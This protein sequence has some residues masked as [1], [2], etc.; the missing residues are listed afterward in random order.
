MAAS[1]MEIV[2]HLYFLYN[3]KSLANKILIF[4]KNRTN[5]VHRLSLKDMS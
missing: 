4:K 1:Y 2:M 5:D 3:K